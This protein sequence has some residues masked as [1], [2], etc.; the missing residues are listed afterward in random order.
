MGKSVYKSIFAFHSKLT[1]FDIRA[2]IMSVYALLESE[3][4]IIQ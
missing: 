3:P 4:K 2:H 1:I